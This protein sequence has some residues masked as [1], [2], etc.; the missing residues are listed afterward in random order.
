MAISHKISIQQPFP[1]PSAFFMSMDERV[2]KSKRAKSH[3]TLF[4]LKTKTGHDSSVR[5]LSQ[6]FTTALSLSHPSSPSKVV[7]IDTS[8][9]DCKSRSMPSAFPIH[10]TLAK[11]KKTKRN[12]AKSRASI[13]QS[14]QL[15]MEMLSS[16][17]PTVILTHILERLTKKERDFGVRDDVDVKIDIFQKLL[18]NPAYSP[19]LPVP[20]PALP[21]ESPD[22]L[23]S[24][25]L[26][27]ALIDED[28]TVHLE[29]TMLF[30]AVCEVS[31]L[32]HAFALT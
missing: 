5:S 11:K 32:L 10:T 26:L 20:T 24:K 27:E 25:V 4:A 31:E 14:P 23:D 18:S 6:F 15:A 17:R 7:P 22:W 28:D 16:D 30:R 21:K 3:S 8:Q 1:I 2:F 9:E 13:A 12:N 29:L 19:L